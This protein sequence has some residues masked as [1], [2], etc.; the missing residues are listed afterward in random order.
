MLLESGEQ[1]TVGGMG[2]P[3]FTTAGEIFANEELELEVAPGAD[4]F[5][6]ILKIGDRKVGTLRD[7][8]AA[9][10]EDAQLL[11]EGQKLDLSLTSVGK[12][13]YQ[14]L[15]AVAQNGK[16]LEITNLDRNFKAGRW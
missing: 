4:I 7:A 2:K 15:K 12:G 8:S 1:L 9:Y 10:L 6:P 13:R 16:V 3:I 11:N 5:V 14:K